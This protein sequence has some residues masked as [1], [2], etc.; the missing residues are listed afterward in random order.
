MS[1]SPTDTHV[2]APPD[3]GRPLEIFLVEDN[4]GDVLLT[5]EA[6]RGAKVLN[7]LTVA[8]NGEEALA[9]LRRE[10]KHAQAARP[11]LILLDLN[12]PRLSGLEVLTAIRTDPELAS[13]PVVM[14][15]SSAAERDVADSYALGVNCYVTKPVDIEQF[16]TVV[17][18]VEQFWFSV[19][20]LPPRV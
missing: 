4:P 1:H 10:G 5:Q 3:C 15:T 17:R 14:L 12:M 19:V 7:R 6:L 13:L 2:P 18:S 16:L 9:I 11:D 8:S 20:T